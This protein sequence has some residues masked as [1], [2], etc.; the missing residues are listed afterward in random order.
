MKPTKE[1]DLKMINIILANKKL[2]EW[3]GTADIDYLHP[4]TGLSSIFKHAV[5]R[6]EGKYHIRLATVGGGWQASI[7]PIPIPTRISGYCED[8]DPAI[9]LFWAIYKV[10]R[11]EEE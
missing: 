9:A 10:M 6:I 3:C 5:P 1:Q 2:N 4:D 8:N 7:E 11:I